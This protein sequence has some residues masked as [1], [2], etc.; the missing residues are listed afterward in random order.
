MSERVDIECR[1]RIRKA[2]RLAWRIG[3]DEAM[4]IVETN[5]AG[6]ILSAERE[7]ALAVPGS[8]A[9]LDARH[10]VQVL[11]RV[12]AGATANGVERIDER[13]RLARAVSGAVEEMLA[14][15]R[16]DGHTPSRHDPSL[17]GAEDLVHAIL[18]GLPLWPNAWGQDVAAA[19]WVLTD[20]GAHRYGRA[21]GSGS[22][23]CATRQERT[24]T[25]PARIDR[26]A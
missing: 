26:A 11:K 8:I 16:A 3:F 18:L 24:P 5:L 12:F 21:A 2:R 22:C 17:Q 20:G 14:P 15:L 1:Q 6:L 23:D 25:R 4:H 7:A 19:A 13:A 9:D 10:D